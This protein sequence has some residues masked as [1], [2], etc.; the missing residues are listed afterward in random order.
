MAGTT[1]TPGVKLIAIGNSRGI[2]IPKVL[3]EKYGWSESI[4]LEET[5]EGLL[6]RRDARDKLSW[7]ETYKAMAAAEEDWSDLDVA[8]ADGL[9]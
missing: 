5:E 9:D 1:S 4:V 3:R 2:R 6:L 7:R 8:M